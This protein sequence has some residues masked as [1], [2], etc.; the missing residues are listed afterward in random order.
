MRVCVCASRFKPNFFKDDI[1]WIFPVSFLWAH[2]CHGKLPDMVVSFMS[3]LTFLCEIHVLRR[4]GMVN[5]KISKL[6]FFLMSMTS[7]VTD[8]GIDEI[9]YCG[10]AL[11]SLRIDAI[12]IMRVKTKLDK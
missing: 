6:T 12:I 7:A 8:T 4:L 10:E 5:Y 1:S 2:A 11:K 3:F 9:G